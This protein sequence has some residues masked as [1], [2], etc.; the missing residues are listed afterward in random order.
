MRGNTILVIGAVEKELED[1]RI[2]Y[3]DL[4]KEYDKADN[5]RAECLSKMLDCKSLKE[6][7]EEMIPL[8]RKLVILVE[9][10]KKK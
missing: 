1:L 10:R 3:N 8:L 2:K 5:Y 4:K 9:E 7:M 6:N